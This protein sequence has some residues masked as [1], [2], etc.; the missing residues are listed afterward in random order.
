MAHYEE[1]KVPSQ[2]VGWILLVLL[3][4]ALLG[5]GMWLMLTIPDAP[6][7]WNYAA[8]P[9][10]P[11]ESV[12]STVEPSPI[13]TRQRLIAPLPEGQPLDTRAA[14][15]QERRER[16]EGVEERTGSGWRFDGL[17]GDVK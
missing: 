1:Y 5:Y 8:L 13:T 11:A 17:Q 4:L 14:A 3:S 6:R 7:R 10:T 15:E 9:D 2:L 16:K 12:Y